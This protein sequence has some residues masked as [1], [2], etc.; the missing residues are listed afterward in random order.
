MREQLRNLKRS[1]SSNLLWYCI[2]S[3]Y[4]FMFITCKHQTS[5]PAQKD[6]VKKQK[7]IHGLAKKNF[8]PPRV[9]A[10]AA[11]NKP[12]IVR[13]GK[14]IIRIDSSNG[15]MPFFND[16]GTDGSLPLSSVLCGTFDKAGNLW[17]GTGGGG[18][19]RFDGKH[20][21]NYS[22]AQGLASNVVFGVTEDKSGNL[23][24]GT[25]S[26]VSKYNGYSFTNYTKAQGLPSNIITSVLQD[27]QNNLWI[28][29][30]EA[31]VSKYDGKRFTNFTT[32]DG[33]PDNYIHCMIIDR[34]GDVW[35]GTDAG[36]VSKYDGC[37]FTN[38]TIKQGLISNNVNCILQDKIGNIWFGTGAGLT[39]YDGKKFTNY[40][41]RQGLT[42]NNISCIQQDK[43]GNIWFGLRTGGLMKYDGGRFT[44]YSNGRGLPG[45]AISSILVDNVGDLWLT[46]QG[47]GVSKYA[48]NSVTSYTSTQ[49]L[50]SNF[51]WSILQDTDGKFWF[52]TYEGGVS[53]YDG[54]SFANFTRT[55]GLADN[56][57]WS[58]LQDNTGRI[59]FATE[60]NGVSKYDGKNFTNYTKAQGLASNTVN[61]IMQDKTGNI[62][63]G[64]IDGASKYDGR[65]FINYATAQGL[66]GDNIQY[67]FQDRSGNLWFATH[68]DGISKYDGN[69]FTNFSTEDG[70][71]SNTV[72]VIRQDKAGNVWFGTNAG[73]SKYDGK[74][75]TSYTTAMGLADNNIWGITEDTARDLLWFATNQGLSG[76]K[77]NQSGNRTETNNDFEN[78]NTNTGYPIKDVST[79]AVFVDK[80]GIL[81]VGSGHDNLIKFDYSKVIKDAKALNLVVENVKVNNEDICW[82][83]LMRLTQG[84]RAVDSLTMLNEMISSFGKILSHEVLDSMY[85]KHGDIRLDGITRFYPVPINLV[86]PYRDNSVTI[87]FVAVEPAL[88]KQVKYQYK[89]EG[90]NKDWSPLSNN[91]AAVFG[92]IRPGTHIFR[93]RALSPFGV[94]SETAYTFRILPPWWL[95][96][97]AYTL[98]VLLAGGILYAIYYNRVRAI[99]RKQAAELNIMAAA[100]EEERKRISRDLHDDIGARLTNINMLSALGQQKVRM[101]PEDSEYLKRISNEVQT[102]AEALDD[103]V[104]SIDT[105][106]DSI[107][108]VTARMR[109]YA[110]EIFDG[111]AVRY[112]VIA[113]ENFLPEKLS[114]AKRRDLFLVF[115]ETIN[116]IQKHAMASEVKINI[117]AQDDSLIMEVNDNGKGFDPSQPTARNGLRNMRQRIQKWGGIFAI[118]SSPGKGATLKISLP[119]SDPSLKRSISERHKSR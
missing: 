92:N 33:L 15:G 112:Y 66:P 2:I 104:W 118:Q 75:F 78:F 87:E 39:K 30:A 68:D 76:L 110:A 53:R 102:C 34:N 36:G 43:E 19:S 48:G 28:G 46:S 41:A 81:W 45:N 90:Y 1:H 25:T 31:G 40:A 86:L 29:T 88:Q 58:I 59:W 114:T 83:N 35:F 73:A 117:Q 27:G 67:I 44:N 8:A 80:K 16:Y 61:S 77:E 17:L 115:K 26:G 50:T 99:K 47:G 23:W 103:I 56:L 91:S 38:Y 6:T 97:W 5:S 64:T 70:L 84:N 60:R 54:R 37:T 116:N 79:G 69:T 13:A 94:W 119:V 52:G 105:K 71:A 89:L 98:Y 111:T 96:W 55:Q 42:N 3:V 20:F 11:A 12:K 93:V 4:F 49:G 10:V 32:A 24:F 62:W 100:Q 109:R 74:R 22:K 113:D 57:V 85:K 108:E 106:N 7:A 21:A 65:S 95:T 51:V 63:L 9:I 14:P 18:V 107:Q 101:Q 82:T 72:Y